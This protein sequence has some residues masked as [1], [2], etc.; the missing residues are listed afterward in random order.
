MATVIEKALA[1]S[2]GDILQEPTEPSTIRQA[3][4]LS[5]LDPETGKARDAPGE[6]PN[7]AV[8]TQAMTQFEQE[9]ENIV[10]K[11]AETLK[12]QSDASVENGGKPLFQF[13]DDAQQGDPRLPKITDAVMRTTP[14]QEGIQGAA[15]ALMVKAPF[16][17]LATPLFGKILGNDDPLIAPVDG[18]PAP[19]VLRVLLERKL[20]TK[21]GPFGITAAGF[22]N[23]SVELLGSELAAGAAEAIVTMGFLGKAGASKKVIAGAIGILGTIQVAGGDFYAD[24]TRRIR[25]G[26]DPG[27][28]LA[29]SRRAVWSPRT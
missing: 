22:L 29:K 19:N 20:G 4:D 9:V 8:F 14:V 18:S 6:D 28:A 23:G 21:K 27:E 17:K 12:Q 25:S 26:E 24:L 5:R 15:D 11:G 2:R 3:L 13:P 16:I 10:D 1:L 7:V